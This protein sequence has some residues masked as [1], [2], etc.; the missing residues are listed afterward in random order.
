MA[1]RE[2]G[3]AQRAREVEAPGAATGAA[4]GLGEAPADAFA[5]REQAERC[6][7]TVV[8]VDVV[9]VPV[10]VHEVER[11]GVGIAVICA[12]ESRHPEGTIGKGRGDGRCGGNQWHEAVAEIG[13]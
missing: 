1:R 10:R 3:E 6:N 11:H 12:F 13:S 5:N 9:E 7:A 4:L 8:V 2:L